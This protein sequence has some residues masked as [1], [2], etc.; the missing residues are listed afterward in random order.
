MSWVT[1]IDSLWEFIGLVVLSAPDDFEQEDFLEPEEQLNLEL[2]FQELR[3]GVDFIDAD[4]IDD[5]K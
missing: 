3:N 4:M 2:A 1:D 5:A